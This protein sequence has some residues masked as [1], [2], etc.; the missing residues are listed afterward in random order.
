MTVWEGG[1]KGSAAHNHVPRDVVFLASWRFT[2]GGFPGGENPDAAC[3]DL[4][5]AKPL[6][7][8]GSWHR[9]QLCL[10]ICPERGG[11]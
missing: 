10:A 2:R 6:S 11:K 7:R 9:D 5:A 4:D 1:R 3:P 8:E